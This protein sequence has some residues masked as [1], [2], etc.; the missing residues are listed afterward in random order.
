MSDKKSDQDQ[1]SHSDRAIY[2]YLEDMFREPESAQEREPVARETLSAEITSNQ[3][4]SST[5]TTVLQMLPQ[6]FAEP[7]RLHINPNIMTLQAFKEEPPQSLIPSPIVVPMP[8]NELMQDDEFVEELA[9]PENKK[10]IADVEPD[11]RV[12]Q[13]E[14]DALESESV[15]DQTVDQVDPSEIEEETEKVLAVQLPPMDEWLDGGRPEWAQ[16]RFECL[17]FDVAGL[18]LAVPLV[19]L[20]AIHQIDKKFNL[21]PGQDDWFIGILRTS[22]GNINVIDTA[23]CVMPERYKPEDRDNLKFVISLH[24][25]EWGLACHDVSN[26]ITLNP[27]EVRWRTVRGKRPWLAG[28]VVDHMCSLIDT[29]GF[30]RVIERAEKRS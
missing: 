3:T 17:L 24:G 27:E 7:A 23:L 13:S 9:P 2:D 28:T 21:L 11:E 22:T 30:H 6:R 20:G 19:T 25:Y 4:L 16:G 10:P 14:V 12:V 8:A 18:K 15:V 26:S 29:E 1:L 5:K